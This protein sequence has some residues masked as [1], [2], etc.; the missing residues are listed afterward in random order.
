[1]T[2]RR[3]EVVV[4]LDALLAGAPRGVDAGSAVGIAR[5]AETAEALGRLGVRV[6]RRGAPDYPRGLSDLTDAPP[7]L[8]VRGGAI[9]ARESM[10]AVVDRKSVV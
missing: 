1:M 3:P 5:A 8:F 10:V 7:A 2:S 6:C 9:P 4:L